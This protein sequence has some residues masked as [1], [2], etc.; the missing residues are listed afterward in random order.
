MNLQ[1]DDYTHPYPPPPPPSRSLELQA[2]IGP[3]TAVFTAHF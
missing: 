1:I 3:S 2:E